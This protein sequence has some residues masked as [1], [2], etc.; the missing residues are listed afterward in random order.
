MIFKGGNWELFQ[1]FQQNCSKRYRSFLD[2]LVSQSD[3]LSAITVNSS[4]FF[5]FFKEEFETRRFGQ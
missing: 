1:K 3:L 2:V 4:E 5:D